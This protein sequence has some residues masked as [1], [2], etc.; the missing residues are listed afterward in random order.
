MQEV[1]VT[2]GIIKT[3][4]NCLNELSSNNTGLPVSVWYALS[5]NSKAL[6]DADKHTEFSRMKLVEKYG[7]KGDDGLMKVTE[8]K[9]TN[10][11]KEY[12]D[13]LEGKTTV[14]LIKIN[15]TELEEATKQL[16]GVQGIYNFFNFLTEKKET[17]VAETSKNGVEPKLENA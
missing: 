10:F 9:M 13:L 7:E 15:I 1:E 3:L 6:E 2:N 4:I 8:E 11:Q 17:P 12:I 14:S 5:H 16:K